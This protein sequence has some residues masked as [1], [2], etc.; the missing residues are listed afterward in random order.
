MWLYNWLYWTMLIKTHVC[1]PIMNVSLY[2]TSTIIVLSCIFDAVAVTNICVWGG[3]MRDDINIK[4]QGGV[5]GRWDGSRWKII[6]MFLLDWSVFWLSLCKHTAN[7]HNTKHE[8]LN[9]CLQ[10][11]SCLPPSSNKKLTGWL[12]SNKSLLSSPLL[13]SGLLAKPLSRRRTCW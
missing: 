13:S 12:V 3:E 4:R 1:F 10:S 7:T 6:F 11:A 8:H 9:T 2:Y 5:A